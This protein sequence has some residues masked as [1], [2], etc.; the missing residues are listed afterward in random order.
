[1]ICLS[2]NGTMT[3]RDTK[4]RYIESGLNNVFISG[5]EVCTCECGEE[6][7][8]LPGLSKLHKAIANKLIHKPSILVGEEIRFI[9]KGMHLSGKELANILG[10]SNETVSRWENNKISIGDGKD[11]RLRLHYLHRVGIAPD[12]SVLAVLRSIN[13]KNEGA[14]LINI[15]VNEWMPDWMGSWEPVPQKPSLMALRRTSRKKI[16]SPTIPPL[17]TYS[18]W[19]GVDKIDLNAA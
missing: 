6:Y 8:G 17:L 16:I 13:G 10:V 4:Y 2:C 3:C 12:E 9:R 11:L 19:H 18:P 7:I 15:D 1:M 14:L 5:V